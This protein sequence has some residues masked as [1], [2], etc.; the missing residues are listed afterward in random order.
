MVINEYTHLSHRR[1]CELLEHLTRSEQDFEQRLS[2]RERQV[3]QAGE[4]EPDPIRKRLHFLLLEHRI[5]RQAVEKEL[6]A[7]EKSERARP[8]FESDASHTPEVL[9]RTAAPS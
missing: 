5:R 7:R 3:P 2:A 4:D 6:A 8:F 9:P 1:L